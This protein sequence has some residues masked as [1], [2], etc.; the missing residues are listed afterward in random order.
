MPKIAYM[1]GK[2]VI[3]FPLKDLGTEDQFKVNEGQTVNAHGEGNEIHVTVDGQTVPGYYD[4]WFSWGVHHHK[5]GIV[6]RIKK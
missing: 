4:M 2:K 3:A 5:N 6:W 1:L